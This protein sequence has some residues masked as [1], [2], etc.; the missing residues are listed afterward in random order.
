[1]TTY[2]CRI[3]KIEKGEMRK[4]CYADENLLRNLEQYHLDVIKGP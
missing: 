4:Q 3:C 1:M 2:A